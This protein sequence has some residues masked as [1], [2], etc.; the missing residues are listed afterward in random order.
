[1]AAEGVRFTAGYITSPQCSPSRAGL[2]TGRY[3]Q[4]F[5]IDT[6]PDLPL[7]LAALTIAERLKPAGYTSGH[8]GKWHLEPNALCRAWAAVN[9]PDQK[10]NAAG[11][12]VIPEPQRQ[13]FM[14]A[15]QGFDQYFTG[16]QSRYFANYDLAGASVEPDW[17]KD[18]RFRVDVQTDAA[19]A[20]LRRNHAKPFFLY[21]CYYA[22]HTP[23]ELPPAYAGQFSH[24]LPLRRRAALSMIAGIDHGVGKILAALQTHGIDDRTLVFFTSDNGAPVHGRRDSPLEGDM[25]G[26]DGSLNTPWVGEKGMLAE[27]GIRVPF[28][29]RWPGQIPAGLVFRH[30]V[31]SLDIAATAN[32]LAGLP[33][34][35]QLDG[36]DLMPH[37]TGRRTDAPHAALFWRFWSQ[38][39]VREGRWKLL[40][41]AGES[42][43][44]FDLEADE[45][46]RRD[47]AA[48]DPARVAALRRRLLTWADEM[49]P[50][51]LPSD[52]VNKEE[53][54]WYREYFPGDSAQRSP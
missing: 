34:D 6:I 29:A 18:E 44:L 2:L 51:G 13:R 12:V 46:E 23:L 42:D 19:L 9:L 15:A 39:A 50:R 38:A 26:W 52:K 53:R 25:G 33:A 37:L 35:A 28:L 40:H 17:H 14:P 4:R 11:R 16:E 3:Q 41:K 5:G 30:P 48:T 1:M 54:V 24:D 49:Q 10:P 32:A 36:V 31:S 20:F 22:P 7:P 47:L 43:R 45:H 27:G 21:L 8:V